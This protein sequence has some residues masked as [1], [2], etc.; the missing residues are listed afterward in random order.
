M[1]NERYARNEALFGEH[2]TQILR[3]A[4][5][6]V[7]GLGGVGSYTVEAL[8]RMGVGSLTLIDADIYTESNLN[9][10]L[11]ATQK[12]LGKSKVD[13]AKERIAEINP[14]ITVYTLSLFVTPESVLSFDMSRFDYVA[15]AIDTVSAKLALI[16]AAKAASTPIISAM[17]AGNKTDPT[18]FRVADISKTKVCP[19]ARVIRNELRRAGISHVK[20][21]Y[22]EEEAKAGAGIDTESGKPIPASC[23]FVPSVMGLIIA[24]EIVKDLLEAHSRSSS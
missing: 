10:Q 3:Q 7:F 24:G 2:S 21:V 14:E 22:S 5:V 23:S 16:K 15:D 19:L 1:S 20:V 12:T 11:Y 17:G 9:R 4:H 13:A 18:L 8:A 6:A